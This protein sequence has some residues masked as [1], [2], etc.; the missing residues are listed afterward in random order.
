[1]WS[2]GIDHGLGYLLFGDGLTGMDIRGYDI[3]VWLMVPKE[4]IGVSQISL[5]LKA[6]TLNELKAH[7]LQQQCILASFP[8]SKNFSL[9]SASAASAQ[10]ISLSS[11]LLPQ[12]RN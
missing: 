12:L 10:E 8:R 5:G 2:T 6:L 3:L 7:V 11:G 4:Y 9:C 1:M